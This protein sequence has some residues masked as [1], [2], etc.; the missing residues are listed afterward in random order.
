MSSNVAGKIFPP[1][2]IGLADLPKPGVGV[3]PSSGIPVNECLQALRV[4][5]KSGKFSFGA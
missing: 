5:I 3:P 4:S 2:K 1:V